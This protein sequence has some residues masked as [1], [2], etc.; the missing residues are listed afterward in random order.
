MEKQAYFDMA[1]AE[2]I[3]W[4]FSVRRQILEDRIRFMNLNAKSKI[5]EIGCGT[6]G[7]LK[8]LSA[9]GSVDGIEPAAEGASIARQKAENHARVTEGMFPN[10]LPEDSG[11]FDLICLFDVLEHIDT[12]LEFLKSAHSVA[13]QGGKILISV[14][15]CQSMW[16]RHDEFLHHKRRYSKKTLAALVEAAGFTIDRI[17]HFNAILF[18]LAYAARCYDRARNAKVATGTSVPVPPVNAAMKALFRVERPFLNRY[19]LPFGLSLLCVA[20]SP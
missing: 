14:P 10:D 16:S 18:P 15:A 6:G 17:T 20:T 13:G 7:N 5:L 9:F 12:D 1:N 11:P 19:N 2:E 8:M 3:H 4:W